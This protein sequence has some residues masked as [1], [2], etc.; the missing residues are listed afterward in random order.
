MIEECKQKNK[1]ICTCTHRPTRKWEKPGF[2]LLHD[3]VFY[4]LYF[5]NQK[6]K[7]NHR[8]RERDRETD[9]QKERERELI[10]EKEIRA[11]RRERGGKRD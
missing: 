5:V 1:S 11:R 4:F 2:I 10:R 9:K 8:E 7:N 6:V 3:C